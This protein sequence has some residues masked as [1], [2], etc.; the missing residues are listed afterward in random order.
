MTTP[1]RALRAALLG[2]TGLCLIGTASLG[3]ASAQTEVGDA[4]TT[5]LSTSADGDVTI[6]ADGSV[7]VGSGTA[8]T[9]DADGTVTNDG[10]IT[11][12]D[13]DDTDDG[14]VGVRI[15]GDVT[16]AYAQGGTI[17]LGT[18]V[19]QVRN[20]APAALSS[21]RFGLL[22]DSDARLTGDITFEN[23]SAVGV[24]GDA[25]AG[26]GI[27]GT[28][29]GTLSL[30]GA[31]DVRGA[32]AAAV[33]VEGTVTG[34][35]AILGQ[36]L[37]GGQA[38]GNIAARGTNASGVVI[39]DAGTVGGR[40]T[41]T[42]QVLVTANT[43]IDPF[44]ADDDA[45]NDL[46][47][48]QQRALAS[49][50]ALRIGGD[51]DGGILLGAPTTSG[52][53]DD[54]VPVGGAALGVQGEGAVVLVDG[55]AVI[56]A[57]QNRAEADADAE[58]GA[59]FGLHNGGTILA[60]PQ[61]IGSSANGLVVGNATVQGGISN[62]GS[63][64]ANAI[65]LASDAT[66]VSFSAD[67]QVARFVNTGTI[68]ANANSDQGDA[69]AFR[70]ASG[71][72][73]TF[74]NEGIIAAVLRD[75][76]DQTPCAEFGLA[77][78]DADCTDENRAYDDEG[79]SGVAV[80][81]DLSANTLGVDFDN[82]GQIEGAV[83]L[84]A[85]A[86]DVAFAGGTMVGDLSTGGGDDVVSF[87][88]T[89]LFFGDIDLGDGRD[90]LSLEGS[91]MV[92]DIAFGA[93]G[94]TLTLSDGAVVEGALSAAGVD[95]VVG[96]LGS[97]LVLNEVGVSTLGSLTTLAGRTATDAEG[98]TFT[99]EG[100]VL[101]FLVSGGDGVSTLDVTGDAIIADDTTF[102][103]TFLAAF[104]ERTISAPIIRAGGLL[105][106]DLSG[107]R[108]PTVVGAS[109]F[110]FSQTL[111]IDETE[112]ALV[113]TLQRKT[114]EE[115]GLDASF[116]P[117]YE[118][119]IAALAAAS[120]PELGDTGRAVGR[121]IFNISNQEDFEDAFRQ[122]LPSPLQAP[123]TYARAQNNSVTSL[124]TQ[125]VDRLRESTG[126]ART[127]WLQ[128]ESFFVNR[129]SDATSNGF[130]GGGF[131]LAV[132]ADAPVGPIDTLGVTASIASARFDE[133]E[134]E[135]FPFN[136]LTYAFG[137]YAAEDIGALRLDGRLSYGI[138]SSESERSIVLTARDEE[139]QATGVGDVQRLVEGSWDGT[140]IAGHL[141]ALYR[142]Q[143][144][145][146]D[147]Q[148]FAS[149]DYLRLE[150]D[151]YEENGALDQA[152]A[153]GVDEREIESL[154][155]NV[156]VV[157]GR[158][159]ALRPNRFD[160]SIPGAVT[161]RIT[162]AY[163]TELQDDDLSGTYRFLQDGDAEG[164]APGEDFTLLTEKEGGIGIL[165]ADIAYE[166]QYA[167]LLAGAS[168]AV[169]DQSEVYTLRL[170]VGLKW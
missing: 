135:D 30:G 84:G 40:L 93:G 131:V 43:N 46:T 104:A 10:A 161:P 12:D 136:R 48:A 49:G 113:L 54:A 45:E 118:P 69:I 141:R 72:V 147:V 51:V 81:I 36:P 108:A 8:V 63:I 90:T 14:D 137:A 122:F 123:L 150:E 25:S 17:T 169:G 88:E 119:F 160:T 20:A 67:A 35:V 98:N 70:D 61:I 127:V 105:D 103:T 19:I 128:E 106:V 124:V 107:G 78:D 97:A 100:A 52:T 138:T 7:T 142:G 27:L 22:L 80:A 85:G 15:T 99:E 74:T 3:I 116:A 133:Q 6:T 146:W 111:S 4:R 126:G 31:I 16:G 120:A 125:R 94:G 68:G 121:A 164:G 23:G 112:N 32:D 152:V 29:D 162:A 18:D 60:A 2:G 170:G 21:G 59:G 58:A 129:G 117:A 77:E 110:L 149:L 166:N 145:D 28:L 73:T 144:G 148:P 95:V 26:V 167:K 37:S 89:A 109:P 66:A 41:L 153:L 44:S 34:D 165:G 53:G 151:A 158:E 155:G 96:D 13:D 168:V 140:E 65:G 86:D 76:A 9:I 92:G 1:N 75:F 115:T 156:G 56:G 101:S 82:T 24:A 102:E 47:R 71:T 79:P 139:G 87:T 114:A 91:L 38:S 5:P 143:Y 11:V 50:N 55:G 163:S 64:T 42:R 134:G 154:R 130:D 33:R 39:G 62:A 157:V 83:L 132:G 159:F 57:L